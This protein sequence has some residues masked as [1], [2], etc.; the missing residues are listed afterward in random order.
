[1]SH[2]GEIAALATAA[3]FVGSSVYFTRASERVG[4]MP[5]NLIRLLFAIPMFILYGWA[6]RGLPLP[7]DASP[8]SIGWLS[9]SGLVGF[10]FGDL[11]LFRA[12]VVI[13]PRLGTLL[14]SLAPPITAIISF[15]VLGERM[16]TVDVFAMTLIVFGIGWAVTARAEESD[17]ERNL[18]SRLQGNE[19][20]KT[21][22]PAVDQSFGVGVLLGVFGALGQAVGLVLSK[23][24][25]G[26]YDPFAATQIRVIAGT[27]AFFALFI[28]TGR[29]RR[30][31]DAFRDMP[32]MRETIVGTVFG[33]FLGVGLSL[34]A[35]QETEAGVAASLMAL[36][37]ILILPV[38]IRDGENVGLAGASGAI[39][40][41]CGVA[42]LF[43]L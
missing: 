24:G 20:A 3:C 14:M 31:V 10:A 22:R 34:V 13:G 41:V 23:L 21:E 11:C 17:A 7:T 5:V 42:L 36:T 26:S 15:A 35:V 29:L 38:S 19:R 37:P 25:M 30:L 43:L 2:L 9:L 39:L 8:E 27:L 28:V 4:S 18:E 6:T 33:P 1:M 32:A 40:A 12:F 16:S